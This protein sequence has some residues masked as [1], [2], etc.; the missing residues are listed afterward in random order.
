MPDIRFSNVLRETARRMSSGADYNWCHMGRCNCG[1]IA[2]TITRKSPQEIHE[3]A[4]LKSGDW[5]D[6]SIEHCGSTGYTIDHIIDSILAY[7]LKRKDLAHI[8]RLSDPA[9]RSHIPFEK[10]KN[11]NFKNRED[12]ILYFNTWAKMIED[13]YLSSKEIPEINSL[14]EQK[15]PSFHPNKTEL[16]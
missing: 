11:L 13:E 12:V 8:E 4:L 10:R 3:M 1:H 2:Q 7:G 6:Q 14:N 15:Q 9:I 16:V 5:K